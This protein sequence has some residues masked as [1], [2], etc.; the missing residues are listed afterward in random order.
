MDEAARSGNFP[1]YSALE[2]VNVSRLKGA[3]S[4]QKEQMKS[5]PRQVVVWGSDGKPQTRTFMGTKD[6]TPK[7][8]EVKLTEGQKRI[9]TIR[10]YQA[11]IAEATAN[12]RSDIA[13]DLKA[14][15]DRYVG[16]NRGN[17]TGTGARKSGTP[18][19]DEMANQLGGN[20]PQSRTA[21]PT[22]TA[23]GGKKAAAAQQKAYGE[24]KEVF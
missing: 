1:A 24:V 8:P 20:N 19:A 22:S 7:T 16:R 14:D 12:G 5:I 18:T 11:A 9:Q 23:A 4:A 10:E 15:L 2:G 13:A 3:A 6:I 17:G 21:A